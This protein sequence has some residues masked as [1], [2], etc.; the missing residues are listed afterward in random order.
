MLRTC[1]GQ[2]VCNFSSAIAIDLKK[3]LPYTD[4]IKDSTSHERTYV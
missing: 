1:E 3:K 4:N 2:H